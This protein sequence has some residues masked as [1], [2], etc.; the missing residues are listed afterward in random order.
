MEN[1]T[2]MISKATAATGEPVALSVNWAYPYC[3]ASLHNVGR[4]GVLGG[5]VTLESDWNEYLVATGDTAESAIAAL[6]ELCARDFFICA[7]GL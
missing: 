7:G 2:R 4:G 5:P 6:D 1:I 3:S